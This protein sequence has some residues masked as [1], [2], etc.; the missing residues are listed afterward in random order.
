[1]VLLG[2]MRKPTVYEALQTKLGR[3]PTNEE[4]RADMKRISD[5][6]LVEL[7]AKGKLQHQRNRKR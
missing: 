1:M 7:A 6:V 2:K 5:E 4:I 3:T